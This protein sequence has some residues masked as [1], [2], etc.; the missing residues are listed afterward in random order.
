MGYKFEIQYKP[1]KENRVA[2]ALSRQENEGELVALTVWHN[3]DMESVENEML[4]DEELRDIA[5]RV[6]QGREV[7]QGYTMKGGVLFWEGRLVLSKNS[8]KRQEMIKDF[9]IH[10]LEGTRVS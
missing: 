5:Q 8:P 2:D 9:M 1:G 10:L 4:N 7:P 3:R 6:L